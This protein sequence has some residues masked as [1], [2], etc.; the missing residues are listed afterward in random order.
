[1]TP[2]PVLNS[3]QGGDGAG[4]KWSYIAV[5]GC[6]R[7]NNWELL[8]RSRTLTGMQTF[9]LSVFFFFWYAFVSFAPPFS[10][11]TTRTVPWSSLY[12][13]APLPFKINQISVKYGVIQ[14]F[15]TVFLIPIFFNLCL[16]FFQTAPSVT[17]HLLSFLPSPSCPLYFSLSP[18][19]PCLPPALFWSVRLF[20]S[21]KSP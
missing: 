16:S 2:R 18:P 7:F 9:P 4:A 20:M 3:S 19:L 8:C 21:V 17:N 10:N 5:R 6:Q 14:I 1:M 12:F 15:L 11:V 13:F